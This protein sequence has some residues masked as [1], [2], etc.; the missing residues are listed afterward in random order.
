VAYPGILFGG[1]QQI[2]LKTQGRV[3]GDQGAVAHWSGDPLTLQMSETRIHISLLRMYFHGNGNSAQLYQNCGISG[4]LTPP[5][6]NHP[7]RYT[8]DLQ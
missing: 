1:V 6:P 5:P 7:P 3:N 2:Q 4:G 8:T